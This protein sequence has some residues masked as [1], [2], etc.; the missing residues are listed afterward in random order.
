[1]SSTELKAEI[2]KNY[3]VF[4]REKFPEGDAGKF[5]VLKDAKIIVKM[6]TIEDA[7]KFADKTFKDELYSIQEINPQKLDLGFISY[8]LRAN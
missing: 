4:S 3:K 1:M 7:V 6:D 8:V 5:V 2:Q